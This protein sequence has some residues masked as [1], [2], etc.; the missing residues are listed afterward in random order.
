MSGQDGREATPTYPEYPRAQFDPWVSL[1]F[2]AL[3]ASGEIC[4]YQLLQAAGTR[5]NP[6]DHAAELIELFLLV[7]GLT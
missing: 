3:G 2:R 4:C 6:L 7:G 1:L 5:S